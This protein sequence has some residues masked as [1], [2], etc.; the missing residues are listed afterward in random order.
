MTPP[1]H[2]ADD[3]GDRDRG[4]IG[5]GAIIVFIAMVVVAAIAGTLILDVAGTLHAQ[6]EYTGQE[7]TEK[8]A[9]NLVVSNSVGAV[10]QTASNDTVV[11]EVYLTVEKGPGTQQL[12]LEDVT[13]HFLGHEGTSVLVHENRH[14]TENGNDD[15]TIGYFNTSAIGASSDITVLDGEAERA[16]VTIELNHSNQV[17]P[18]QPE[19]LEPRDDADLVFVTN[20]GSQRFQTIEV[21][22]LVLDD[23]VDL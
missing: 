7:A 11:D 2:A 22:R 21:P 23:Y 10:N 9:D 1:V 16:Q 15:R 3:T 12:N 19:A 5:I 4:Q 20:T 17:R 13:I 8:A 6:T 18:V 14:E